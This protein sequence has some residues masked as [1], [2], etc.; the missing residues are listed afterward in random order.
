MNFAEVLEL[1]SRFSVARILERDDFSK[2][3]KGGR[4][5][6]LLELLYPVIQGYDSVVVKADVEIGG[7]DQKYNLLVG[8]HLQKEYGLPPQT[9]IT[10]PLLEGVDGI[11]KMSKSLGNYI[12]LDENPK[13]MFGKL[14]SIPD[15]LIIKYFTL[16]TDVSFEEIN[17]YKTA[18]EKDKLNPKEVKMKL[19]EEILKLY[20]PEVNPKEIAEEF[21]RVFRDK[22]LPEVLEEIDLD[23][24]K[25]KDG[26][27]RIV[28]LLTELKLA[29]SN[30][31]AKRLVTQG[32]VCIDQ[33]KVRDPNTELEVKNGSVIKVGKKK[34]LKI[35][36]KI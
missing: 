11:E 10:F 8:R 15:T 21:N 13:D 28:K 22:K 7:T 5:I 6:S 33:S 36:L 24:G 29:S 19:G 4:Y 27:I 3:Y 17:G 35:K 23:T 14:M 2:R 34:F 30:S 1:T 18:M 16:L 20:H 25:L 26:K 9:V 12:G 32:G 31:H